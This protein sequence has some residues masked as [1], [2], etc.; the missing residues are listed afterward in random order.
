[1]DTKDLT[2]QNA[3]EPDPFDLPKQRRAGSDGPRDAAPADAAL[4][5][6]VP[7]D[8][9][10]DVF[11]PTRAGTAVGMIRTSDA[12]RD[13]ALGS[14]A[15][16]YAAG[17][18]ETAEFDARADDALAARTRA[19]LRRLFADL[20]GGPPTALLDEPLEDRVARYPRRGLRAPGRPPTYQ[21]SDRR[22]Y[23]P[24]FGGPPALGRRL[25]VLA[26]VLLMA[27]FGAMRHGY[28]PFP[29]I[30]ALF[31]LSRRPWR[32]NRKAEPWT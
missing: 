24:G 1:M 19:D 8:A 7:E 29:L 9:V 12:E 10:P 25:T 18:L 31:I 28:F 16:H 21:Q 20:P 17:R 27:A 11:A 4:T 23:R 3:A 32:W 22:P 13:E 15:T 6:A 5:D 26:A 2:G 30:P 14:L